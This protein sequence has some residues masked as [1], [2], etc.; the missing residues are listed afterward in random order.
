MD[1][2]TVLREFMDTHIYP[3]EDTFDLQAAT[4]PGSWQPP[5]ILSD[6]KAKARARG[7]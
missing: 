5:E 2:Q 6:L 1:Y 4:A 3:N 7:L